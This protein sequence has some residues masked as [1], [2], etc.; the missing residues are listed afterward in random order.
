MLYIANEISIITKPG[1]VKYIPFYDIFSSNK[2]HDE[3]F[4]IE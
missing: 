1:V 4:F 2:H 3:E